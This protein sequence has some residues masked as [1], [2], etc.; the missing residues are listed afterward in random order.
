MWCRPVKGRRRRRHGDQAPV[1]MRTPL[2]DGI[3]TVTVEGGGET[4][5]GHTMLL[6]QALLLAG[7]ARRQGMAPHGLV[8]GE[9]RPWDGAWARRHTGST[10]K[11]TDTDRKTVD[12]GAG[13]GVAARIADVETNDGVTSEWKC[14]HSVFALVDDHRVNIIELEESVHQRKV[15]LEG[16]VV[17]NVNLDQRHHPQA[18]LIV[19]NGK[20]R[21]TERG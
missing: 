4:T 15:L 8:G 17:R 12:G 3:G 11:A 2:V 16:L 1:E 7:G 9:L 5:G 20:P 21:G 13:A 6:R 10:L 19:H 18:T 14:S